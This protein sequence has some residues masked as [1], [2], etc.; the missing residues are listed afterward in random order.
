MLYLFVA[1]ILSVPFTEGNFTYDRSDLGVLELIECNAT[2][3]PLEIPAKVELIRDLAF[4]LSK[5]TVF[6]FEAGSSIRTI[7]PNAFYLSNAQSISFPKTYVSPPRGFLCNIPS[8]VSIEFNGH[9]SNLQS[10]FNGLYGLLYFSIGTKFILSGGILDFTGVII[11][12]AG[13]S[14]VGCSISTMIL[15]VGMTS[16]PT[17]FA[18]NAA[19]KT[20][21]FRGTVSTL[22]ACDWINDYPALDTI[23]VTG[24]PIYHNQI[25]DVSQVTQY[26]VLATPPN[27]AYLKLPVKTFINRIERYMSTPNMFKLCGQLTEVITRANNMSLYKIP[28]ETWTIPN[29]K[30][31]SMNGVY[32]LLNGVLDLSEF[33]ILTLQSGAF[34]Y[35]PGTEII[36]PATI[37]LIP[38]YVFA[39]CPNLERVVIPLALTDIPG[40]TFQYDS[41]LASI[42]LLDNDIFEGRTLDFTETGIYSIQGYSFIGCLKIEKIIFD[43]HD[44]TLGNQCFQ[45]C[46]NLHTIE[47]VEI[48]QHF[49][50]PFTAEWSHS[51]YQAQINKVILPPAT[52]FSSVSNINFYQHF[53]YPY[54]SSLE[55]IALT[56]P[57]EI[58]QLVPPFLLYGGNKYINHSVSNQTATTPDSVQYIGPYAFQGSTIHDLT[59]G[60]SVVEINPKAFSGANVT[61]VFLTSQSQLSFGLFWGNTEIENVF[62]SYNITSIPINLFNGCSNLKTFLIDDEPLL[63]DLILDFTNFPTLR[64]IGENS[65]KGV[66]F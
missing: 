35:F 59:I 56:L 1:A 64:D 10:S 24:I 54:N 16:F 66:V 6:R 48:P 12:L 30:T 19:L 49:T 31:I 50:T 20:I 42:V 7:F 37:T 36:L 15:P 47:F 3:D 23:L 61:N 21:D 55:V 39:N 63:T 46:S 26:F 8:L 33:R 4:R 25:L 45:Q 13:D 43:G 14:F 5:S 22:P 18:K 38:N 29:L 9:V 52:L 51:F 27:T 62:I 2:N 40:N 65:F 60:S 44:I 57:D 32:I 28:M 34:Q 17:G 41:N 11:S 58:F 53:T